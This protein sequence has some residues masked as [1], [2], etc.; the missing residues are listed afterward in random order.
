MKHKGTS[1]VVIGKYQPA[2]AH[3]I[4]HVLNTALGNVGATVVY[5]KSAVRELNGESSGSY[6]S[7]AALANAMGAGQV[8]TLIILD[9]NPAFSTPAD[10]DFAGKLAKVKHVIHQGPEL[11]ETAA[12]SGWHLPSNHFLEEWGDGLAYDGTAAI[13]QPLIQPLYDTQGIAELLAGLS[14]YA[15]RKSHEIVKEFWRKQTVGLDFELKWRQWLHDGIIANTAYSPVNPGAV[16]GSIAKLASDFAAKVPKAGGLEIIFRAHP[17]LYDGRYANN[18]WLQELPD[19]V[20]KLT[21]D[22]AVYV[23]PKLA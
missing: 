12:L 18:A 15:H 11:N 14:G 20:T 1:A 22:N 9:A 8:E 13:A 23:S 10:L 5:T 16:A 2:L 6:E 4:G 19:P 17:N 7:I 21:W 3:A